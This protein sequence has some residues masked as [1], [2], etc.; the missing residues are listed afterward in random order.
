MKLRGRRECNSC[1]TQWSYFDTEQI[2][3]PEC[4]SVRSTSVEEAKAH[5]ASSVTLDLTAVRDDVDTRPLR[6][7]ADAAADEARAFTK[8]YGFVRAGELEPLS[9]TYLA[10]LELRRVGRTVGR[11]MD[12]TDAEELYFLSLLRGADA[13]E[14]PEPADVPE[15][16]YPERGLAIAAGA[17][18]Y[19]RDIKRAFEEREPAVD[20]VLQSVRTRCKRI[21]ALDGAV[22]PQEAELLVR[23]LRDLGDY[24]I[25]G[26]ETALARALDRFD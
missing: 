7:L 17:D 13:G 19:R 1:G 16:F 12:V 24:L 14:R 5:T 20:T 3:C 21:E 8:Q 18:H 4:G 6:E 25:D 26:H 11:L 23:A 10:A 15:P 22:D 9:D 2:T